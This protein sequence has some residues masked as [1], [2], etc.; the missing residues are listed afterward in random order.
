M[1]R[2]REP[3]HSAA[4]PG[5][6]GRGPTQIVASVYRAATWRA[7]P[8]SKRGDDIIKNTVKSAFFGS[9]YY[10]FVFFLHFL[11]GFLRTARTNFCCFFVFFVLAR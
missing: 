5:Q 2:L 7:K 3:G 10:F 8:R 9:I 4:L 11:F 1:S 6:D